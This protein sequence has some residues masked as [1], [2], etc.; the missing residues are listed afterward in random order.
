MI[1]K[2]EVLVAGGGPAGLCAAQAAAAAGAKVLVLERDYVPGGQLAK[3][4]HKFFG[5]EK[6]HAGERGFQIGEDLLKGIEADPNIQIM[7]ET[8]VLG[9]YE[10]GVITALKGREHLKFRPQRLIITTGAAEKFL[11]FHRE[12]ER[13]FPLVHRDLEK[14]VIDGNLLFRC[15]LL[16]FK[17]PGMEKIVQKR[18][19]NIVVLA[20]QCVFLYSQSVEYPEILKGSG[21]PQSSHFIKISVRNILPAVVKFP[22][23][24]FVYACQRIEKRGFP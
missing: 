1:Q 23:G 13:L 2:V 21:N 15:F 24:G 22:I 14:T 17:A 5:S 19:F 3:Q 6:Q 10:D 11:A 18:C 4:T 7:T 8:T 9:C 16:G 20:D 12:L